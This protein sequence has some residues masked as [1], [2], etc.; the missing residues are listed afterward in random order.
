MIA[1]FVD[2]LLNGVLGLGVGRIGLVVGLIATALYWHKAQG[3]A[4]FLGSW[5]GK[6][7]F[8]AVAIGLLMVLGVIPTLDLNRALVL[9][10]HALELIVGLIP[11]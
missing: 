8:S 11:V 3:A 9:V 6:V 7:V 5:I 2:W 4:A 10:R 1:D